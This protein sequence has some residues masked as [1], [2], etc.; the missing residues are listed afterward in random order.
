MTRMNVSDTIGN[1]DILKERSMMLKAINMTIKEVNDTF[2]AWLTTSN[3]VQ[4]VLE[5]NYT[6]VDSI[7]SLQKERSEDTKKNLKNLQIEA[8]RE[9]SKL[10][11]IVENEK[12]LVQ[13]VDTNP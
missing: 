6:S 11:E 12:K 2:T 5:R 4:Q 8:I 13:V 7:L 9:E 3:K 10:K 1:T